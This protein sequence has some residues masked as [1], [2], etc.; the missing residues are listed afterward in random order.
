[1]S[2]AG[3]GHEDRTWGQQVL[4]LWAHG[5]RGRF[6]P[7]QLVFQMS[8]FQPPFLQPGPSC[9][10]LDFCPQLMG[11]GWAKAGAAGG[12]CEP[13]ELQRQET[14]VA[15]DAFHKLCSIP[16]TSTPLPTEVR[17]VLPVCGPANRKCWATPLPA[18]LENRLPLAIHGLPSAHANS[19]T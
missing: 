14:E 18:S 7:A 10:P 4:H 19:G 11:L 15:S 13:E 16:S 5:H 3:S 1:M 17:P 9:P 2:H 6:N 8:Q 12:C